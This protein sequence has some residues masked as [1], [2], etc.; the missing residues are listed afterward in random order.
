MSSFFSTIGEVFKNIF[1]VLMS[2]F[3]AISGLIGGG[4]GSGEEVKGLTQT[5]VMRVSAIDNI[6]Q[7]EGACSDGQYIYQVMIE[8]ATSTS[9]GKTE[10]AVILKIDPSTWTIVKKSAELTEINHANDITY[11]P[12]KNLLLVSNN[13]PN[14]KMIS[15]LKA[16]SLEYVGGDSID[17]PLYSLAYLTSGDS[18]F[19]YAGISGTYNFGEYDG[20]FYTISTFNGINN[21]CTRQSIATDNEYLYCLFSDPNCIYK[22]KLDGTYV[23]KCSLPNSE[24]N[25]YSYEAEGIFFHNGVL[26]VTYNIKG[27]GNGGVICKLENVT[28]SE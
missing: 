13:A 1:A 21:G 22:Y 15:G 7:F 12:R 17:H 27:K 8:P 10:K 19:Y 20:G 24:T 18:S 9:T 23:G 6:R 5:I 4:S 25:S 16:D 3:T 26:Y 28:Y 2:L 11:D 14:Y